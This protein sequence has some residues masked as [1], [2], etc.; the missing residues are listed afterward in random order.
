MM[1]P[2]KRCMKA[3]EAC[4][5]KAQGP[6]CQRCV[7][8]KVGCSLVGMKRRTDK[9]EG[10][11][12]LVSERAEEDLVALMMELSDGFMEQM[13]AMAKELRRI[14]GGIWALIEGVGKLTEVMERSEKMGADKVE[15]EVETEVIQKVDKEMEME[16]LSEEESEEG[17]DGEEE[18]ERKE[19][20]IRR[21]MEMRRVRQKK[22]L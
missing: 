13:E 21:W 19:M 10:K 12:R 20:E 17:S 16:I 11:W 14:G 22:I 1:P 6:G 18:E 3:N 8:R 2:C 5:R 9:K 7:Q 15:K 4:L